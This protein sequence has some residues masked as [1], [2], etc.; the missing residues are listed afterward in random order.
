MRLSRLMTRFTPRI[1]D[2]RPL[3]A[4]APA[5]L[6]GLAALAFALIVSACQQPV[7]QN[8]PPAPVGPA[9]VGPDYLHGTVGSL[10]KVRGFY[11]L[12]VS[13]YGIVAKLN[14]TGS[15]SAPADLRRWL[16]NNMR[17]Q[18]F[19]RINLGPNYVTAEQFLASETTAVVRIDGLIPAGA[20]KGARFDVLVSAMPETQ[21]SSLQGGDLWTVDLSTGGAARPPR[22]SPPLA[23]ARG[24][25]VVDPYGDADP[26][27]FDLTELR[28]VVLS[29]GKVVRDRRLD[30]VLNQPSWNRA[31]L[32]ADRI[33]ERY[34]SHP[35][36]DRRPTAEDKN[37]VI[38][39]LNVPAKY[40]S[41]PAELLN[42]IMHTYLNRPLGFET[43]QPRRLVTVLEEDPDQRD[44]VVYALH[45]LGRRAIPTLRDYYDHGTI[46][47]RLAVLEAAARLG[48]EV[49]TIAMQKL[50]KS[51]D[52]LVRQEV[53][54]I[55]VYLPQSM[56]GARILEQLVNDDD[57][58]V[59]IEAYH[60]L[61]AIG[62]PLVRR[63]QVG[64]GLKHKFSLDLVPSE[65]PMIYATTRSI[66]RLVIFDPTLSFQ[67]PLVASVPGRRILLRSQGDD[68][69]QVYYRPQVGG[70]Q[71][72]DLDPPTVANLAALMGH[73]PAPDEGFD[74]NYSD[75]V[76][77][78]YQLVEAGHIRAPM[79]IELTPLAREIA[80]ASETGPQ[81]VRPETGDI[82]VADEFETAPEDRSELEEIAPRI[83]SRSSIR[84]NA[85][86][87]ANASP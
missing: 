61:T 49:A 34:P 27:E 15:S 25:V 81:R 13:G 55:L 18:G 8:P 20:A 80:R 67:T 87:P 9:V 29:G 30:L 74:L 6:V 41:R 36:L 32:I 3:V 60:S 65:K 44:N 58:K 10:C 14:G 42:L 2:R 53:A 82:P 46:F 16:L 22:F 70:G 31:R 52:P 39:R 83:E 64:Q 35:D 11:P 33:V 40:R 24:P 43:E 23:E 73:Y 69:V 21:T 77:A 76:S 50:A 85:G 56:R 63:L 51:R 12:P 66:P 62:D 79:Q 45:A 7:E 28:G 72:Y 75:V 5:G 37:D 19:N 68:E 17:K 1:R 57:T 84:D 48:D 78:I 71:S 26:A 54:R 38:I 4:V 59:R 86:E 47:V